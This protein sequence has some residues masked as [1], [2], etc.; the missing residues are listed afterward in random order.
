MKKILLIGLA[1][2]LVTT[3]VIAI[4]LTGYEY[5]LVSRAD[6]IG[7]LENVTLVKANDYPNWKIESGGWFDE[8]K[9]SGS[10]IKNLDCKEATYDEFIANRVKAIKDETLRLEE[11]Q[12]N[13][14]DITA[15]QQENKMLKDELCERDNT[16][17][18]C[19]I[20]RSGEV[21]NNNYYCADKNIY[22]ICPFGISGGIGT[23]CYKTEEL[24]SWDYC[25][26][27]WI[28]Q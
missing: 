6:N 21:V 24:N 27:G 9:K 8:C 11:L 23:R 19:G 26:T 2:L 4:G 13:P 10:N 16:Y 28:K 18:W 25:S 17:S 14:I 3:S 5:T 7:D 22:L 12:S 15:L 20:V 1:L